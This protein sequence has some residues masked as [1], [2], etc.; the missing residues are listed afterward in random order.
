MSS[1]RACV[2]GTF[3][4]KLKDSVKL[5]KHCR[6]SKL[7]GNILLFY[8]RTP[9]IGHLILPEADGRR[10]PRTMDDNIG[11]CLVSKTSAKAEAV[12]GRM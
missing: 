10:I 7:A 9:S 3:G 11:K 1:L 2:N 8:R 5:C 12:H 4:R 6:P